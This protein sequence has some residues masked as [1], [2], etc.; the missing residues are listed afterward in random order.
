M[1]MNHGC[2]SYYGEGFVGSLLKN[3]MMH[4]DMLIGCD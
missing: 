1:D 2:S 4:L 3:V